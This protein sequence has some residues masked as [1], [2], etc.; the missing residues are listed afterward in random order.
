MTGIWVAIAVLVLV[1]VVLLLRYWVTSRRVRR[2]GES[3]AKGNERLSLILQTGGIRLWTFDVEREEFTWIQQNGQPYRVYSAVDFGR[4]YSRE[5]FD[6]LLDLLHRM[7]CGILERASIELTIRGADDDDNSR[8]RRAMTV[9][10]V[11]RRNGEGR[12]LTILG[13]RTDITE[14]YQRQQRV[15]DAM[16]RYQAVFNTVMVDMVY[17]DDRGIITDMNQKALNAIPGGVDT[18]RKAQVSVEQVLAIEGVKAESL[19]PIYLTQLFSDGDPRIMNRYLRQKVSCYELQL[20]PIFDEGH[21]LKCIYG[22]GRNVSEVVQTYHEQQAAIASLRRANS[23]LMQ[24][25]HN[26]D[27]AMTVGGIRMATYSPGTH[28]L[29][30]NRKTGSVERQLTQMHALALVDAES[31]MLAMRMFNSMD[32][33]TRSPITAEVKTAIRTAEGPR[34]FLQFHFVPVTDD[35]G[36]VTEYFGMCRDISQ[37]K[38][39]ERRLAIETE[40]A[41]EVE[42]VKKSFLR[43]M[44]YEIRTPLN[45]VMGFAEL[46]DMEHTPEEEKIFL[47]EIKNNAAQLLKLINAILFL[48]RLD[49]RMIEIKPQPIDFAQCFEAYC[50]TGW[51]TIQQ[52]GVKYVVE[53][54]YSRLVVNIDDGN[55]GHVIEQ[56]TA[57]AAANTTKGSVLTRYD[58]ISDRLIVTVTDTGCGIAPE[59]MPHIYERFASGQQKGSGLGLPICHEL[60]QQMGG[61][62]EVKSALGKGT[63]VWITLPCQ[64]MEIIRI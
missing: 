43:N 55:L 6:R 2:V 56:V 13:T 25:V 47:G 50:Q 30:I 12:P 10:S 21:R 20:T 53:N 41:Q 15:K 46:F 61:T 18:I 60:M 34:L 23:E 36:K 17:Y 22:S 5:D 51:N 39:T 4:R 31:R 64:A 40:R 63:T 14:D 29:T 59:E 27:Y 44:S 37:L 32:N 49:A 45:T 54:P 3:L 52:P 35:D 48:S 38:D 11:L 57:N 24:Y 16:L 62:I 19:E 26:I 7:A 33:L 28:T 9:L 58:Y 1:I 8:D 42:A